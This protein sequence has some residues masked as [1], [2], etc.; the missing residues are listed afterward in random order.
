MEKQDAIQKLATALFKRDKGKVLPLS[1]SVCEEYGM[2]GL[3]GNDCPNYGCK[4]ECLEN[5]DY[6]TK[7]MVKGEL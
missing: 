3:C 5:S 4:T 6:F 1:M 2:Q 7:E